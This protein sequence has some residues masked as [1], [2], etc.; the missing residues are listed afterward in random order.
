MKRPAVLVFILLTLGPLLAGLGYSLAYSVG[1]TGLL[2]EGFTTRHWLAIWEDR[3]ILYTLLYNLYITGVSM[4]LTVAAALALSWWL[5]KKPNKLVMGSLFVPLTFP[6]IVAGFAW[7]YLLSPA[8]ILSRFAAQL[9]WIDTPEVF[10]RLVND[11]L[12]FGILV[13]HVF[14]VAPLFTLLFVSQAQKENLKA[15]GDLSFTLGSSERQ[16][17]QKVFVPVLLKKTTPFIGLYGLF[18]FG[19]YEIPLLLGRSSPRM[20]TVLITDKLSR[21]DLMN[22]PQAHA[23]AVVYTFI[24][25]LATLVLWRSNMGRSW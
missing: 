24:V 5:F 13:T 14:L 19:A 12:S 25:L 6:P 18:L 3:T 9:G 11:Y 1:W 21:F 7:F 2:S 22:I 4:L 16:F 23:L 15:L 17:L 20:F 8:G 10:P